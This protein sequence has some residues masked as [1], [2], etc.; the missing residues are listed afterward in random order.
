MNSRNLL[1]F[2]LA[3]VLFGSGVA[4]GQRT[5]TS[6]FEKYAKAESIDGLQWRTTQVTIQSIL[7]NLPPDSRGTGPASVYFDWKARKAKAVVF[8]DSEHLERQTASETQNTLTG[9]AFFTLV[10]IQS[11]IPEISESDFEMAFVDIPRDRN[12]YAEYKNGK[13]IFGRK[14]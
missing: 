11:W 12:P 8:V 7:A 4:L 1:R 10:T 3:M 5:A 6:K 13:L 2:A 14:R 9:K